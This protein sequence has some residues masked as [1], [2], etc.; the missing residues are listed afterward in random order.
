MEMWTRTCNKLI[1]I[2][3]AF[4]RPL[5]DHIHAKGLFDG[6]SPN[7]PAFVVLRFSA[8]A[9]VEKMTY[10]QIT[11]CTHIKAEKHFLCFHLTNDCVK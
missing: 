4:K 6:K 3:R 10:T 1:F 5:V 2:G 7:R 8:G 9:R 11:V